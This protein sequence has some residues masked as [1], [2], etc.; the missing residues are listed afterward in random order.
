MVM[1]RD[2]KGSR[3]FNPYLTP[4]PSHSRLSQL[5]GQIVACLLS[6][7][8]RPSTCSKIVGSK[9]VVLPWHIEW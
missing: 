1:T 3:G 6:E 8:K 7:V 9:I 4:W 2:G 5:L